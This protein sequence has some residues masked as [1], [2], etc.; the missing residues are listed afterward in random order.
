M[1][2]Y[3]IVPT[4]RMR[5]LK[6]REANMSGVSR[7]LPLCASPGEIG[8]PTSWVCRPVLISSDGRVGGLQ[9]GEHGASVTGAWQGT[10][11]PSGLAV[12]SV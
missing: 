12:T 1:P 9:S 10:L 7:R 8:L 5:K 3:A 6:L 4:L 11:L 2:M